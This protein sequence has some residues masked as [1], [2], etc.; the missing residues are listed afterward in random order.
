M[1][2]NWFVMLRMADSKP[3]AMTGDNEEIAI[4]NS[5]SEA[6]AAAEDNPLGR[7]FGWEAYL[8]EVD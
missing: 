1:S 4:F 6:E 3:V 5:Y 2:E 7:A 8:W